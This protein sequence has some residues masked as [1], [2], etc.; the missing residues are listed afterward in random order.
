MAAAALLLLGCAVN[1]AAHSLALGG[2]NDPAWK[3]VHDSADALRQ[4]VNSFKSDKDQAEGE[5][6]KTDEV[7]KHLVGNVGCRIR[8]LE[9][10]KAVDACLP[11]GEDPKADGLNGKEKTMSADDVMRSPELH[12]T[13][14]DCQ[15][16]DD[17]AGW[18]SAI[19]AMRE[20]TAAAGG[21]A[22]VQP[23][24]APAENPSDAAPAKAATPTWIVQ[25]AGHHYHNADTYH[26]GAEYLAET[27][28]KALRDKKVEIPTED[29]KGMELV[30]MK[31]LG[32]SYPTIV[33]HTPLEED[34]MVDPNSE[35]PEGG[36]GAM[37]R[38]DRPARAAE[39]S[40]G[41]KIIKPKRFD[42]IVQFCWQPKTPQDRRKAKEAENA[43]KAAQAAN[44]TGQP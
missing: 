37:G 23:A 40:S 14:F 44:N 10:L 29:G 43:K 33:K 16:V 30:S 24:D 22:S 8:W 28:I 42:F 34:P 41:P 32:V 26:Q 15:E 25:L 39:D 3:P 13:H 5:F 1:Y 20:K 38:P 6:N 7:G 31:E 17:I 4:K 9:L 11:R 12:I 21:T 36:G 19:E 35:S 18:K 27:L 2:V